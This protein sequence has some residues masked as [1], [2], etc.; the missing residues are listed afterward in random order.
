MSKNVSIYDGLRYMYAE[1]LKN[2]RVTLKIKNLVGGVDFISP[3]GKQKG[4]DIH[5]EGTDKVLGIPGSTVRRQLFCA[6][7][8]DNPAEMV[9]KEITLYP[10][11]S[12][13]SATGQAIRIA[14]PEHMA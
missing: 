12:A 3:A 4:F 9:G 6:T 1:Q 13:R 2:K 14:V 8:T 7:G 5:F 10:V 11:K